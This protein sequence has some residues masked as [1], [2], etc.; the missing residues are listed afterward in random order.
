M[1]GTV[2]Y[3]LGAADGAFGNPVETLRAVVDLSGLSAG[4]HIVFVESRDTDG[5]WGPP[6]ATFVWI[7]EVKTCIYLPVIRLR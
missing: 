1:T 5:N 6:T 3:P 7:Y 4:R 2:T